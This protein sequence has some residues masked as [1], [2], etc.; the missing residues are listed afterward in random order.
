M[1]AEFQKYI[2]GSDLIVR[3]GI[4]EAEIPK[5]AKHFNINA[6]YYQD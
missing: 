6:I 1:S 2:I 3:H 5:I 4:T